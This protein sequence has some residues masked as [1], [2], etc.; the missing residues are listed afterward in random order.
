MSTIPGNPYTDNA[1]KWVL[2]TDVADTTAASAQATLALAHEQHQ[3][4]R[5]AAI[6]AVNRGIGLPPDLAALATEG[7]DGGAA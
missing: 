3:R 7:T 4:N 1:E 5:L 6:T 2:E